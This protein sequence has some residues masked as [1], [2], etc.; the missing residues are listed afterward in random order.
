VAVD[1]NGQSAE[2][3]ARGDGGYDAFVKALKKCLK[4]FDLSMPKLVDYE[5][6]IPPGG[7]TDA[8]VETSISWALGKGRLLV[9][10]GID[11]DQLAAAIQATEK[12]LNTAVLP[13]ETSE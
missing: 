12:M 5:E 9:T 10:T 4:Q 11:S 7:R 13:P 3:S 2:A 8:L 6:R 1:Y